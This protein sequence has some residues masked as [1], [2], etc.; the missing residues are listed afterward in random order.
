V[1]S[2][3]LP[4]KMFYYRWTDNYK[5]DYYYDQEYDDDDDDCGT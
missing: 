1:G 2:A 3:Q 5:N 4:I